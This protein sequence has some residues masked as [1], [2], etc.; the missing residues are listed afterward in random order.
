[1]IKAKDRPDLRAVH[2]DMIYS[3][4][5]TSVALVPKDSEVE[6]TDDDCK[7][8]RKFDLV[9]PEDRR[10]G[11]VP[12]G[13]R[14]RTFIF[15]N[16]EYGD[17]DNRRLRLALAGIEAK[18]KE[19]DPYTAVKKQGK[20]AGQYSKYIEC[21]IKDG[22]LV[23]KR[24]RNAVS[25]TMNRSGISVMFTNGIDS[26]ESMMSCYDCRAQVEQAFGILKNELDGDKWKTFDPSSV[27]GRSLIKFV[28]LVLWCGFATALRSYEKRIPV[29]S[30]LQSLDNIMAAGNGNEWRLTEVAKKNKDLLKFLGLQEPQNRYYLKEHNVIR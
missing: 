24:K 4:I 20:V 14:M 30:A 8:T 16:R 1:M 13:K 25:F 23:I 15:Y 12:D 28:S 19:M 18:L 10:F 27:R 3:M 22:K 17:E 7:Y 5:E 26:W 9:T 6:L 21:S 29:T 11:S 2:D